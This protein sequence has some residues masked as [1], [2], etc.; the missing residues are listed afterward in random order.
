MS[1][2]T[3][4]AKWRAAQDLSERAAAR[5]V[6]VSQPTLRAIERDEIKRIGLEIAMRIVRACDGAVTLDDFLAPRR[7]SSSRPAA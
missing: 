7:R 2:G 3:K 1:L 6:G 4:V 5:R